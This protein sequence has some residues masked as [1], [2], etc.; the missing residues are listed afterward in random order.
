LTPDLK[1]LSG[2]LMGQMQGTSIN[3]NNSTLLASL[4]STI[5]F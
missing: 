3:A 1:T 4:G 5:K 2:D